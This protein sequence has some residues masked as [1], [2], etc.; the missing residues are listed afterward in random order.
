MRNHMVD[1]QLYILLKKKNEQKVIDELFQKKEIQL[2]EE[3]NEDTTWRKYNRHQHLMN[4]NSLGV[5]SIRS[6]WFLK[7][8]HD[9]MNY[10]RK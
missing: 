7:N 6:E 1:N 5:G 8:I 9:K 3:Q 2:I 4:R 10:M